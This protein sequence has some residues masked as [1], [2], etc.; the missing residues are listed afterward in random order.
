MDRSDTPS[1][2]AQPVRTRV[3]AIAAIGLAI[4]NVAQFTKNTV[5]ER[6]LAAELSQALSPQATLDRFHNTFYNSPQTLER[7]R[8]M[9]V[10]TVQNPND[11]WITQE[12]LFEVKPDFVVEAGSYMG[13]SA[14]MWALLLREVNPDGR[15]I[16]VDI[17]DHLAE[18]RKLPIFQERVEFIRGSSTAP[19][20]IKLVKER[21]AGKRVL[22][23]LDSLHLKKHVLN[24]L[25]AYADIVPVGSYIIVQDSDINGHPVLISPQ[26]VAASYAG[27]EGPMEAIEEF[28]PRDGR[29]VVDLSRE[30][31]MLTMN[32]KGFLRR[33]R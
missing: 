13:G 4:I 2:N 25:T 8:W 23:I 3:W 26:S 17:E 24:E 28:L 9:G 30:R 15:I 31:L 19:E 7:N 21:V 14:A 32:P 5:T 18:A 10:P 27:Q 11:V 20:V 16:T 29:F 22:L 6:A 33:V 1:G 12:I